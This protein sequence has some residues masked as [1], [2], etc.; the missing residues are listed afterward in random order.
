MGGIVFLF[1]GVDE[2]IK[3]ISLNWLMVTKEHD[4]DRAV[5]LAEAIDEVG[6][7]AVRGLDE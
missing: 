5:E 4:D 6:Q 7:L 3:R 2:F 1:F